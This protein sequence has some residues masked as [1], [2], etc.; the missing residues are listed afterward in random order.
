MEARA[1]QNNADGS[2]LRCVVICK[3]DALSENGGLAETQTAL[4]ILRAA[5]T[6]IVVAAKAGE[7]N[8]SKR[9][10]REQYRRC[11][12]DAASFHFNTRYGTVMRMSIRSQIGSAGL[13]CGSKLPASHSHNGPDSLNN[14]E[15]P[16]SLQEAINRAERA[17]AGEG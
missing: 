4:R 6:I 3:K 8:V 17:G 13:F 11:Y 12:D 15:R 2:R 16:C 9:Q 14:P 1:F 10:H 7:S 5:A